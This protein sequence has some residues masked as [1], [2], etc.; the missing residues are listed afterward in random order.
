MIRRSK[1]LVVAHLA[2]NALLLWLGYYWLGVGESRALTLVWSAAVALAIVCGACWLHGTSFAYFAQEKPQLRMAGASVMRRTVPLLAAVLLA[3]AIYWLLWR[4]SGYSA[5]PA[6]RI[7]S[8]LTMVL[9]KPVRPATVLRVFSVAL[10]VTRWAVVPVLLFP[11][12]A[13]VVTEGWSGFRGL[14]ARVRR[15]LYWIEIPLLLLCALWLPW[16]LLG[17]VPRAHAFG[18]ELASLAFRA[19]AAYLFFVTGW[20]LLAFFTSGGS[21]RRSQSNIAVSP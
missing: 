15:P 11:V 7:A 12:A 20:L 5:R 6:F 10:W 3:A 4:W 17:W 16:K 2:G 8:W 19:A 14:G 9:R 1:A 18:F 13:G 21:P